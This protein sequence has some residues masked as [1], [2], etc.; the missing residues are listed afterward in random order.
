LDDITERNLTSLLYISLGVIIVCMIF[1]N[2]K[3]PWLI[4][5]LCG[6][7]VVSITVRKA[8]C[9]EAPRLYNL[10]KLIILIDTVLVFLIMKIDNSGNAFIFYFILLGDSVIAYSY[11]FNIVIGFLC[12]FFYVIEMYSTIGDSRITVFLSA[13]SLQSMGFVFI[14]TVMFIVKYE[15]AQR[16]KLKTAMYEL[17]IKNKQM[18]NIYIK[19]KKNAEELQE[20]TIL[21]ERN[22]IAREIHDTVGHTLTTVLVEI[23]AGERLVNV[24]PELSVEKIKLAKGQVRKGLNDIRTS[25]RMLQSGKEILD[26]DISLK[27]LIEETTKFGEVFIKYN[28]EKLPKLSEEVK[29][30]IYRAHQ[31]GLTNGIKHGKSTAFVFRL[32][33]ENGNLKFLLQ[34]N[35]IGTDKIIN[36]FG[37]MVMEERTRELGGIFNLTSKSGEGFEIY[38]SIPVGEGA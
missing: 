10:G 32:D 26:F 17:K 8:I 2:I 11:L 34:D 25:V 30:T 21:K 24:N 16:S 3:S 38:I 37:L 12:F 23:E 20:M 18:E 15:I 14:I 31:E 5:T 33:L 4:I 13:I 36:S 22:R 35:G 7:L 9:D 28:I 29:T 1:Q 27:L 19:L 6:L